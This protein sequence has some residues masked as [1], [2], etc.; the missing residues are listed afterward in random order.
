MITLLYSD[1]KTGTH[2]NFYYFRSL[3]FL[4]FKQF[5]LFRNIPHFWIRNSR[6]SIG[7]SMREIHKINK[8]SLERFT[9]TLNGPRL[10]HTRCRCRRK[11]FNNF[12]SM[13]G[14]VWPVFFMLSLCSLHTL[15]LFTFISWFSPTNTF[16]LLDF[17]AILVVIFKSIE[18]F[19]LLSFVVIEIK[20]QIFVSFVWT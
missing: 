6:N 1:E 8:Y 12:V 17:N 11:Y 7:S 13:L 3:F 16:G 9:Q 18:D 15:V 19:T 20:P 5:W 10:V 4:A 14:T 2:S